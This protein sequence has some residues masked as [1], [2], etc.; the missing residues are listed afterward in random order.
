MIIAVVAA[1]LFVGGLFAILKFGSGVETDVAITI[2]TIT[3]V[4]AGLVV[5]GIFAL[6]AL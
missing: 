2:T 1:I 4:A 5:G 3:T 6:L